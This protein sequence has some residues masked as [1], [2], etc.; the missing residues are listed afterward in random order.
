MAMPR[1]EPKIYRSALNDVT[2][3]QKTELFKS[4]V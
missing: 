1:T 4:R 2:I 3:E